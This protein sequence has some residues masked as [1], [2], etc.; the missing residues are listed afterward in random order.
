MT[1]V[2]EVL[3][4]LELIAKKLGM[5]IEDAVLI[6][7]GKHPTHAVVDAP[8]KAALDTPLAEGTNTRAFTSPDSEGNVVTRTYDP[9]GAG[10]GVDAPLGNAT[11]S[12]SD[13]AG[14]SGTTATKAA[15]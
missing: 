13:A 8:L 14:S 7:E 1:R 12:T 2:S 11:T 3:N 10:A 6:L 9:V 15:E 5:S 4:R